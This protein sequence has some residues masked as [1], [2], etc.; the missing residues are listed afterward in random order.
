MYQNTQLL[1]HSQDGGL[2]SLTNGIRHTSLGLRLVPAERG[3]IVAVR[4]VRIL[5]WRIT[6]VLSGR[7]L[8]D[9]IYCNASGRCPRTFTEQRLLSNHDDMYL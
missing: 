7:E 3:C 8:L 6:D 2:V 9:R 5:E 4:S 1:S